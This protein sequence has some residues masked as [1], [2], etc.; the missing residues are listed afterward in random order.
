MKKNVLLLGVILLGMTSCTTITKTA[1]TANVPSSLLS[2]TVADLEVS[3]K[4]ITTTIYPSAEVRRGGLS[5]VKQAA[6]A[7]ALAEYAKANGGK[8]ADLLVEPEYV[9]EQESYF[10]FGKKIKSV[11]VSGRPATYKGFRSLNDSVW[12]NP[13]F[14]AGFSD[15]TRKSS[16]GFLK[17]L[18]K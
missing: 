8:E 14:R 15:N 10:I 4:R 5:N 16:G 6:E 17:G 11:T 9:V 12:C 2:T 7:Q 13:V 1:T 3:P 18:F